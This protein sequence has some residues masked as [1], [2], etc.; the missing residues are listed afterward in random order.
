M[1][2][3]VFILF[4]AL[5]SCMT[6]K[7]TVGTYKEETGKEYTYDKAKQLYLFWGLIP[8]GRTDAKTPTDGSCEIITKHKAGDFLISFFTVGLLSSQTIIVKDKK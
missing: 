4:L 2:K 3:M 1:K 5:S 7:T 8:L 6:T